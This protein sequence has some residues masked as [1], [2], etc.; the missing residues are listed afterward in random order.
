MSFMQI[1]FHNF[2]QEL[3]TL[4][5]SVC[6]HANCVLYCVLCC[7]SWRVLVHPH[8][9][10]LLPNWLQPFNYAMQS[11]I[12]ITERTLSNEKGQTGA[13]RFFLKT[14]V[15]DEGPA[16]RNETPLII[17]SHFFG[18]QYTAK[19]ISVLL[20]GNEARHPLA[21]PQDSGKLIFLPFIS[22]T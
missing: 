18:H 21:D 9:F 1:R 2:C 12:L 22:G 8:L 3:K 6:I 19:Q 15:G 4:T 16:L 17:F 13:K 10:S 5:C 11:N 14:G 20:L 7:S